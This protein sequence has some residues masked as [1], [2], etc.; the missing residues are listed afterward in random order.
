MANALE[1]VSTGIEHAESVGDVHAS[2][3]VWAL[4][5]LAAM[6]TR[7]ENEVLREALIDWRNCWLCPATDFESQTERLLAITD[8]ALRSRTLSKGDE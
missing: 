5:E 2:I 1:L 8:A 3:P 4:K 7:R 6:D